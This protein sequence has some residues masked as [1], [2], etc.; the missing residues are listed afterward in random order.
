MSS[1]SLMRIVHEIIFS[2]N[3]TVIHT[4]GWCTCSPVYTHLLTHTVKQH[5]SR[6]TSCHYLQRWTLTSPSSCSPLPQPFPWLSF[7]FSSYLTDSLFPPLSHLPIFHS[8]PCSFNSVIYSLWLLLLC[9]SHSFPLLLRWHAFFLTPPLSFTPQW[10]LSGL[11]RCL[12]SYSSPFP[13]PAHA[14]S[15]PA[16]SPTESVAVSALQ[17]WALYSCL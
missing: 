4:T 2:T 7:P 11:A 13:C 9:L 14:G 8:F 5:R 17:R 3:I 6:V 16:L 15:S 10:A 12:K 1:N